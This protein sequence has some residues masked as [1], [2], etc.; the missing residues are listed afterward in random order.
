M[1]YSGRRF[2]SELSILDFLW[3]FTGPE[4][5]Q[6]SVF[7]YKGPCYLCIK[8]TRNQE[9]DLI[10]MVCVTLEGLR[11]VSDRSI[12]FRF[13]VKFHRS[14]PAI[15]ST[16]WSSLCIKKKSS[17]RKRPHQHGECYS[18]SIMIYFLKNCRISIFSQISQVR[19]CKTYELP[20]CMLV[21]HQKRS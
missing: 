19:I 9:K 3:S 14:G 11:N 16:F 4:L 13:F 2:L 20:R 15:I 1:C 7:E 10:N 8:K 12:N 21:M 6:C 5:Q 18:R 17:S